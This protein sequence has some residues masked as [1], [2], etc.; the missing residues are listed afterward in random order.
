LN[1]R[2]G[3]VSDDYR[4]EDS[5]FTGT[6]ESVLIEIAEGATDFSHLVDPQLRLTV[7]LAG[8]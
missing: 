3:P 2:H 4:P 6:V 7:A 8:Q 5:R 1:A